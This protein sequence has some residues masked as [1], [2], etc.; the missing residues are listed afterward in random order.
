MDTE[1]KERSSHL[2]IRLQNCDRLSL[3]LKFLRLSGVN[4]VKLLG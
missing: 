4:L 2:F 1:Q 3:R